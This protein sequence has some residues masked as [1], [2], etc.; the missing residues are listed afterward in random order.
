MST[1]TAVCKDGKVAIA[2]DTLTMWGSLKESSRYIENHE[3]IVRVGESYIGCTGP[4]SV[5]LMLHEFFAQERSPSALDSLQEIFRVWKRLHYYFK[6]EFYLLPQGDEDTSVE[7][8]GF[9][10]LIANASGI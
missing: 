4:A 9:T 6:E 3:K 7:S 10:T 5:S 1:V 2:A 8:S